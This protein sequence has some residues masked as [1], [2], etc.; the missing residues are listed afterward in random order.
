MRPRQL[1]LAAILSVTVIG[2]TFAGQPAD[3]LKEAGSIV[4]R[5]DKTDQRVLAGKDG[6]LFFIGELR[7]ISVGPFWGEVAPK[8]SQAS[9]AKYADPLPA[10]LEFKKQCDKA[11]VGLLLVPVPAKA[12][13]YPDRISDAVKPGPDGKVPRLDV[14]HQKF[15]SILREKGVDVLDPTD[16]FLE[17]RFDKAGNMYCKHDTHWS[18]K[19]CLLTAKMIVRRVKDKAWV[20]TA[21]RKK[22]LSEERPLNIKGDL[23]RLMEGKTAR[24]EALPMVYVGTKEPGQ[25]GLVPTEKDRNSPVVLIGDSHTLVFSAGGDLHTT[26]A[27]LADHLALEF[28]FPIDRVGIRG[29]GVTV[30]RID[31]ARRRDNLKGKKLVIWCFSSR[32]FTECMNGWRTGVPVVK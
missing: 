30:P 1:T 9:K 23:W 15:Y 20:Q 6:W 28:G 21:P 32:Q 27:G 2:N 8:V 19:A 11:G 7:S 5:A 14:H 24:A 12:F 17:K 26:G 3:F 31:L 25:R 4:A 22:L 13:I 29:A 18:S 10:I 16:V